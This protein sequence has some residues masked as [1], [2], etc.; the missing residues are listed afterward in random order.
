MNVLHKVFSALIVRIGLAAWVTF[1]WVVRHSLS[2]LLE[3]LHGNLDENRKLDAL[4]LLYCAAAPGS[5]LG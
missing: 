3:S 4:N 1:Q 2:A 5:V